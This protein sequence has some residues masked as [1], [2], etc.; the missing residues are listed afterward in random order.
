MHKAWKKSGGERGKEI[1]YSNVQNWGDD[2][3]PD[4]VRKYTVA[5][6]ADQINTIITP[7]DADR[8]ALSHGI[9]GRGAQRRQHN[10]FKMPI[11]FMSW[12]FAA[13]NK[14]IIS[15]LQG[16]HKGQMSG[17]VAMV[18]LGFMSDYVRNPSYWKQKSTQEKIIKGVEYSGLTAYWLDVSNGIE[19]MTDNSFGLRP[20]LGVDN[21]FSG[22]LG[23][24]VSEP[25]GPLG[26]M[27]AD[28]VKM[29]TDPSLSDNRR[30]S[31]IRRLI[32]YNNLFYADWLFKGAQKNIM[33]TN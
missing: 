11:Q 12:S 28:I 7:T 6:R 16:R 30:A 19:I 13:N 3:D 27:G 1:Y 24:A 32:P 17:M 26:S 2:V 21:P 29:L 8:S 20:L 5:I 22:T 33:G 31:I 23:D 4:L 18:A 9:I 10:F 15:S 25:F 14:I